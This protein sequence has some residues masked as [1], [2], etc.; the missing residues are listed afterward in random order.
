MG[1]ETRRVSPRPHA[2]GEWSPDRTQLPLAGPLL[3]DG[4]IMKPR[5]H[6]LLALIAS[7]A[8]CGTGS[9]SAPGTTTSAGTSLRTPLG[10]VAVPPSSAP[11]A[12]APAASA[13]GDLV[14]ALSEPDGPFFSDNV[15][16][17]ETSYLQVDAA[18]AKVAAPGGAY[19]GVGPEQNFTYIALTRPRV[20]FIVDIR[21][22]NMIEHLLYKAVFSEAKSRANFLA[23]LLGRPWDEAGDPGP[24][25]SIDAVIAHAEKSAADEAVFARS[26]ALLRAVIERDFP[27][28]AGDKKTLELSHRGFFKGQLE[29]RFELKPPQGRRYPSLRE[30]L[31][32]KDPEGVA[33]GFLA[34]EEAFRFVQTM[35]REGRVIPVVGDFA[36]DRALPGIAAY[37]AREKIPVSAFYTSNVEQYLLEPKVWARWARNVAAL[38]ADDRSLFIRAYLDQGRRHPHEMKGHRTAT[39]LQRI[40]DFEDRQGKKPFTTFWEVTT[41]RLLGDG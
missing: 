18:L 38:P 12:A 6:L 40:A 21:R 7:L 3:R 16:S 32:Q 31:V 20:A 8:A 29:V 24:A 23:L 5:S 15:V 17:N 13:F 1:G 36:G 26:H 11:V 9:A 19:L 2:R 41:E 34:S 4:T 27:L 14:N 39:V 22:Q 28:D 37:L 35:E 33:R 25:A 30:L 10:S